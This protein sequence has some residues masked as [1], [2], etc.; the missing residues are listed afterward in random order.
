MT[1]LF[2]NLAFLSFFLPSFSAA[3]EQFYVV[4]MPF[5]AFACIV[6]FTC[7]SV[8]VNRAVISKVQG[9]H[10]HHLGTSAKTCDPAEQNKMQQCSS[11]GNNNKSFFLFYITKS[12]SS[13]N[14]K[15]FLLNFL[16][17]RPFYHR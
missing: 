17:T 3:E 10:Q 12:R 8:T 4:L 6:T 15:L 7:L 1:Q 13:P 14:Q 16:K 5:F 9:H 2:F 11:N